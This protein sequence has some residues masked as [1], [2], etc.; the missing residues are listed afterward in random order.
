MLI[1]SGFGGFA[2]IGSNELP[3]NNTAI[4]P[5]LERRAIA[6]LLPRRLPKA[7][8]ARD[9]ATR[10]RLVQSTV[11]KLHNVRL[12]AKRMFWRKSFLHRHFLLHVRQLS[13]FGEHVKHAAS[14]EKPRINALIR[15]NRQTKRISKGSARN[16]VSHTYSR[17]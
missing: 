12:T 5:F 9:C 6:L 16:G 7:A 1:M 17:G 15:Y 11:P 10:L 2:M 8:D 14:K 4:Y 13:V 3:N